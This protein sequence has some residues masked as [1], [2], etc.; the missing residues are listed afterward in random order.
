LNKKHIVN[1]NDLYDIPDNNEL[2]SIKPY[3]N[4]NVIV[5]ISNHDKQYKSGWAR[6]APFLLSKSRNIIS[7]MIEPYKNICV[8]CHTD[9]MLLSKQPKDIK[10]GNNIGELVFEYHC[11]SLE[12]LNCNSVIEYD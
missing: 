2:V 6:I 9:S 3:D 8:R 11:K 12:V 1:H 5:K 4:K 10:L 7:K